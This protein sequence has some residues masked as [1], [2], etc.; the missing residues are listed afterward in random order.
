MRYKWREKKK[1]KKWLNAESVQWMYVARQMLTILLFNIAF[2]NRVHVQFFMT[3]TNDSMDEFIL[4]C[5]VLFEKIRR[6]ISNVG[7]R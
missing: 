3:F 7:K 1:K 2:M 4:F 5:F 6:L